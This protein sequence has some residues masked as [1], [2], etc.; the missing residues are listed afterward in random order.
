MKKFEVCFYVPGDHYGR[1]HGQEIE[2]IDEQHA[3][4]RFFMQPNIFGGSRGYKI[5]FVDAL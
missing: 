4:D 2:A 5:V 1:I 3:K